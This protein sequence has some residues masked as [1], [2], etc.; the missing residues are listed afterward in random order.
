MKYTKM[1]ESLDISVFKSGDLYYI[2]INRDQEVI[3]GIYLCTDV[4][5][6]SQEVEFQEIVI[7]Q[8]FQKGLP[9]IK[10]RINNSNFT[11]INEIQAV[12]FTTSYDVGF[13][14]WLVAAN[15]AE[16]EV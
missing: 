6:N 8:G 13:K 5:Y 15:I 11:D 12:K 9:F 2:N 1:T 4:Y 10:M 3:K 7:L 14:E 16:E